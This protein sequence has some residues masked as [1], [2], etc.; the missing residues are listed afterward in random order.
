LS[1][2]NQNPRGTSTVAAIL[3]YLGRPIRV[4]H[5]GKW[6]TR[7]GWSD[8]RR[9]Q[10]P[11]PIGARTVYHCDGPDLELAPKTWG[12]NTVHFRAGLELSVLNG[13]L[14]GLSRLRRLM[15]LRNL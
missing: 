1:P 13:M 8:G 5:D 12:A 2:G 15:P 7:I 14:A 6:D 11:K 10:F 9:V 4:W 3:T